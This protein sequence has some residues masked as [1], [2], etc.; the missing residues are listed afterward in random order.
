MYACVKRGDEHLCVCFSGR[1]EMQAAALSR[2]RRSVRFER[3]PSQ[4]YSRR[5]KF[6]RL[7]SGVREEDRPKS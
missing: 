7:D 1:T 3:K 4:R 2:S 6:E 5:P